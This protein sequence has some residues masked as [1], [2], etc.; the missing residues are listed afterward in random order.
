MKLGFTVLTKIDDWKIAKEAENIGFDSVWFPDSQMIWSDCYS[1]MALAA[2]A[3]S[4][5]RLG[6]GVSIPGTRIAPVT[7][8]S[9]A[10]INQLAPG[11]VFLGIGTGHTAM[12][13]MGMN[14]MKLKEFE[15]YLRVTKSLLLGEEVDFNFNGTTRSIQ[16]L[17][18]DLGFYNLND[19]IPIYVAANGPKALKLAGKY[20]DGLISAGIVDPQVVA[21]SLGMVQEGANSIGRDLR[22]NYRKIT[23]SN[24]IVLKPHETLNDDR[25]IDQVGAMTNTLLH[26]VYEIYELSGNEEMIPEYMLGVWEEFYEFVNKMKTPKEKR[27]R[28]IHNGHCTFLRP[29]ERRFVTPEMIRGAVIAGTVDEVVEEIRAAEMAGLDEITLLPSLDHQRITM[30]ECKEVLRKL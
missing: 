3:T 18:Q 8:Q 28:E 12:R 14:P 17:H 25:V 10:G 27:Y 30:N 23:M 1:T 16:F 4:K 26:F 11:R 9:I 24:A 5:I 19:H 6:T 20:G 22:K 21:F 7:A 13:V 2:R 15:E 29:E